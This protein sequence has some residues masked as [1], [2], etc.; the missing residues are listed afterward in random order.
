MYAKPQSCFKLPQ[1]DNYNEKLLYFKLKILQSSRVKIRRTFK[2][3]VNVKCTVQM[4]V[5]YH[6]QSFDKQ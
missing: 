4:Y 3:F 5:L 2:L 6:F 1:F